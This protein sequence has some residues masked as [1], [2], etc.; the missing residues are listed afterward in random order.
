MVTVVSVTE[1]TAKQVGGLVTA[2]KATK[3]SSCVSNT[4]FGCI[5]AYLWKSLAC[6][7][8][9]SLTHCSNASLYA[10]DLLCADACLLLRL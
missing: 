8:V 9:L 4:T 3:E 7:F 10:F 6:C 1:S 2:E 5:T